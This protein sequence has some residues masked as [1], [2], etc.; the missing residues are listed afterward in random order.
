[1]PV[2]L[3]KNETVVLVPLQGERGPHP[4]SRERGCCCSPELA[5]AQEPTEATHKFAAGI[6]R[7]RGLVLC[8]AGI[9]IGTRARTGR[10]GMLELALLVG[11]LFGHFEV[12]RQVPT[13]QPRLRGSCTEAQW[14]KQLLLMP[15]CA[16]KRKLHFRF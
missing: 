1:M 8:P 3:H 12:V 7:C 2:S 10:W 16:K 9:E 11:R 5:T 6:A 15:D 13:V 14:L 4:S